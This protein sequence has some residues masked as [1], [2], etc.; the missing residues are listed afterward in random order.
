VVRKCAGCFIGDIQMMNIFI[1]FIRILPP[2][3]EIHK[4][5]DP[6]FGIV[7]ASFKV[8]IIGGF[9]LNRVIRRP[10]AR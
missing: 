4:V 5:F 9:D 1:T 3:V 2:Q 6:Y 10:R 8:R 7:F